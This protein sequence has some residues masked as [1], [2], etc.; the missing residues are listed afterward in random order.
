MYK[1]KCTGDM[2]NGVPGHWCVNYQWINIY[3]RLSNPRIVEP[4]DK[5]TLGLSMHYHSDTCLSAVTFTK[6][7]LNYLLYSLSHCLIRHSLAGEWYN[8]APVLVLILSWSWNLGLVLVWLSGLGLG[9][10]IWFWSCFHHC[11]EHTYI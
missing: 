8:T 7:N 5:R 2:A 6:F 4:S 9:L 10:M 3:S 1:I 11:N